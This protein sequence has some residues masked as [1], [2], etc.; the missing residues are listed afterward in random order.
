MNTR[1]I[2]FL[3]L[4][5]LFTLAFVGIAYI[6]QYNTNSKLKQELNDLTQKI[7]LLNAQND[8]LVKQEETFKN[9]IKF[10]EDVV[11][12]NDKKLSAKDKD[13]KEL[14]EKIKN[15]FLQSEKSLKDKN[16]IIQTN[17]E[18]KGLLVVYLNIFYA[19]KNYFEIANQ[20]ILLKQIH[21]LTQN[22]T[23]LKDCSKVN[24]KS[25]DTA[26]VLSDK[27]EEILK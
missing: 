21:D 27:K 25:T 26:T 15:E 5:F 8:K 1:L 24:V 20:T 18:L 14:Q 3:Q 2:T 13:I 19:K 23:L 10:Y 11:D 4:G 22:L 16:D 17:D 7:S 9:R 12:T 6:R